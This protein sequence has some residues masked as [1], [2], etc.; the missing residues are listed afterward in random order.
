MGDITLGRLCQFCMESEREREKRHYAAKVLDL[1]QELS[2]NMDNQLAAD[3][4][5]E[6]EHE[7]GS[8][9]YE[10]LELMCARC[11]KKQ[12]LVREVIERDVTIP[13]EKDLAQYKK[14]PK[15]LYKKKNGILQII[16]KNEEE[17]TTE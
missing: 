16:P 14:Q 13:F 3:N 12:G 9:F 15:D 17:Q 11:N 7:Q 2:Y 8:F 5:T 1:I 6:M 4:I 10:K